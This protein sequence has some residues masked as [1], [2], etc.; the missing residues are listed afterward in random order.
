MPKN[1]DPENPENIF[2]FLKEVRFGQ[3]TPTLIHL[4]AGTCAFSEGEYSTYVPFVINGT[5][6]VV[7]MSESGRS[8]MLYRVTAG[9]SCV[10]L[11]LSVLAGIPY[12]ADAIIEEDTQALLMPVHQF[13]D[14]VNDSEALRSFVCRHMTQRLALL[15]TLIEEVT[16][17]RMDRR[18]IE[19]ILHNTSY[20]KDSVLKTHEEIGLELG[21]AREVISRLLKDFEK[22]NWISVG[23]GK[24]TVLDRSILKKAVNECD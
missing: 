20:G 23:R 4:P 2:P 11:M 6:R 19:F 13:N 10:L 24:I 3:N 17:K 16:F 7:K 8:I 21:T 15:M 22:E 14:L 1:Y 9:E 12:P 5:I 18:L